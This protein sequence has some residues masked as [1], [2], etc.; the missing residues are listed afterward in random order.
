METT[1]KRIA[2]AALAGGVIIGSIALMKS[3]TPEFVAKV[4]SCR[5]T[6]DERDGRS[7]LNISIHTHTA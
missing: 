5:T 3:Y 4:G 2:M 1:I 6:N 7:R